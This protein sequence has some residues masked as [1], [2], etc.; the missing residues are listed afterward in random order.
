MSTGTVRQEERPET[1]DPAAVP[2]PPARPWWKWTRLFL[3]VAGIIVATLALWRFPWRA[4]LA[5]L[6]GANVGL[7]S[8]ALFINLISLVAKGW[9]WHLLLQ[10]VARSRWRTAQEANLVGAA[11]NNL[12]VSVVG[13]ATRMQYLATRDGVPPATVM[14]SILGTRAVEALG[15]ALL[16]LATP[17]IGTVPAAL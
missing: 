9:I 6:A 13:E 3:I 14:A 16:L 10:P 8:A 2:R 1:V 15:L 5:A 11:V 7:L 4:T 17:F 12:S